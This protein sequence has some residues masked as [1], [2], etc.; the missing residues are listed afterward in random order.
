MST[1]TPNAY[2][3]ILGTPGTDPLTIVGPFATN[4]EATA[5]VAE[6][7]KANPQVAA[8]VDVLTAPENCISS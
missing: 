5:H 2:C 7:K 8:M 4:D 3:I 1:T 6:H